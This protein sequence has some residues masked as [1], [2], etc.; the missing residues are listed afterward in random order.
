MV[1]T[2]ILNLEFL[3]AASQ[4][5]QGDHLEIQACGQVEPTRCPVCTST[6]FRH[7]TQT[8]TYMD[9]PIRGKPVKVQIDRRR[10]RCKTCGKTFF[11]PLPEMDAKR[12]MTERLVRYIE[13]RCVKETFVHVSREVGIDEKTVRHIFDDYTTQLGSEITFQTP[14]ILGIDEL[15][16][17][18]EYR[19]MITNVEKLSVFDLL[20]TRLKGDLLPYFRDLPDKGNV[21]IVT[22]D[23]WNVYRQVV[24]AQ[25][26]GRLIVADKFHVLRM[27]NN[28]VERVRKRVRRELDAKTRIRLK[29]ERF[30]LLKRHHAL[31]DE[32]NDKLRDWSILFPALGVAHAV[33][34]GFFAIYDQPTRAAAEREAKLWLSR[35][36]ALVAKEF[37]ETQVA[38]NSWWGEIFNWYDYK[39]TNA[40][41]ESVN[42]LAKD[43][44][45]MGR[46]Y[47][48]DVI[49]ARLLFDQEAR[50]PTKG[51]IRKKVRKPVEVNERF[52]SFAC[53]DSTASTSQRLKYQTVVEEHVV[54]YGPHIPTL[55]HLFEA[56]HFD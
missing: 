40:Y 32:E 41:T 29:N 54:E 19:A 25:L 50:K 56:G 22:M 51:V 55:C 24:T 6:L 36:D 16:I 34:E 17:I 27:A 31:T 12:N 18:G 46:G 9:A 10:Y 1:M 26:P 15:K 21:K 47:S 45:R 7:G 44:N 33:K 2:D 20:P 53:D 23:M 38:L 42:R 35:I 3:R 11:E 37:R 43:V 30:I 48:F 52:Y 5:D 4:T 8:Q 28:A 13:E 49:R 39:V 14:E